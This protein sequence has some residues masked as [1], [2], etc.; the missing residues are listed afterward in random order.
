MVMSLDINRVKVKSTDVLGN[1]VQEMWATED[2]EQL[3]IMQKG[4]W[5]M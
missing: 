2:N 3:Y 5:L 4:Q 1:Y